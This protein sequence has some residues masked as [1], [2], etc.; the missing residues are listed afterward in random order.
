MICCNSAQL[1]GTKSSSR[2][3]RSSFSFLLNGTGSSPSSVSNGRSSLT[4]S[5]PMAHG[6]VAILCGNVRVSISRRGA[7]V[8]RA[9]GCRTA[10]QRLNESGAGSE[11][12]TRASDQEL[13]GMPNRGPSFRVSAGVASPSARG[14]PRRPERL[15]KTAVARPQFA[16]FL[17]ERTIKSTAHCIFSRATQRPQFIL[18]LPPSIA[19]P[20]TSVN[21]AGVRL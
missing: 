10:G 11:K 7:K 3:S 8:R 9:C 2:I 1:C 4:S 16:A 15:P 6:G 13:K 21:T 12:E 20:S 19:N 14:G 5:M 18:N 17:A